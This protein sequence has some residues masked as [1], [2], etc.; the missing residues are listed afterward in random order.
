[1][2]P[3]GEPVLMA[4]NRSYRYGDGIFETMKIIQGKIILRDY[5]FERLFTGLDLLDFT[6]PSSFSAKKLT[7]CIVAVCRKNKCESLARVRL[8]VS[9]GN[10][11]LY[12]EN[13]KM[14][15][16]IECWPV[17]E[18]LNHINKKGLQIDIFPAAQKNCDTYAN[19]KSANY[20]PYIMAARYAQ[21][22]KLDDCLLC[23]A[24]GR[25]ADATIANLFLVKN[26]LVITPA[27][28]EGCVSGVMRKYIIEKLPALNFEM[29]EGFVTKNDMDS[30]DEAFLTNAIYGIRWIRQ[31]G[32]K[33]YAHTRTSGIF[34]EIIEPLFA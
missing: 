10:G 20:L 5:H 31:F 26:N 4:N 18:E 27:L 33:K 17:A 3:A 32:K 22:H 21:A 29:R 19:L 6:V 11:G 34:W 13:L 2:L 25:I 30:F 8:S 15:W 16:L 9:R 24:N 1:M 23:N 28:T 14:Q 12:D 7:D